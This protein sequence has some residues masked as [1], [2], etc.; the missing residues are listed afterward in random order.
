MLKTIEKIEK[1]GF[2]KAWMVVEEGLSIHNEGDYKRAVE[3]M[4]QLLEEIGDD[5]DHPLYEYLDVLATMIESYEKDHCP[6]NKCSTAEILQSLMEEH[7]LRQSDLPEIGSQGVVS[8]I[9]HGK[10]QLT[11]HQ[12]KALSERFHV[13]PVTFID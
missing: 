12:I 11:L 13:T 1:I 6:I 8:E 4:D 9:L 3:V 7:S 2:Q 5:E 10:R